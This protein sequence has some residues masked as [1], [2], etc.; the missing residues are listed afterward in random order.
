M[1]RRSLVALA[2]AT[3]VLG[4]TGA[5]ADRGDSQATLDLLPMNVTAYATY[6]DVPSYH[7][8]ELAGSASPASPLLSDGAFGLTGSS[9]SSSSSRGYWP[10]LFSFL[11]PGTGEISMGYYKRGIALV[12]LEALAWTGYLVKRDEGLEARG[13]FEAFADAHW[14]HDRWIGNHLATPEVAADLG[15]D[16]ADVTFEQLDAYGR[17]PAWGSRWP[18]YHPYAAKED[19][20][21]NYYENIGKYD[22]FIS[23]W[24]DWNWDGIDPSSAPRDTDLRTTYRALRKESNDALDTADRFIYLSLATRAFSLVET[25]ILVR[26]HNQA[27]DETGSAE[28][29]IHLTARSRGFSAGEVALVYSFR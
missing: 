26:R 25:V 16:P 5:K 13:T 21:L 28:R 3:S 9:S 23:G 1:Y 8:P 2:L 11:V 10:V 12:A 29:S 18:G 7:A 4:A 20:K 17:S 27:R 24:E 19:V 6:E 22:W 14:D 15:I